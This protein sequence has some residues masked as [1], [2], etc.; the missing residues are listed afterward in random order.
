MTAKIIAFPTLGTIEISEEDRNLLLL[1]ADEMIARGGPDLLAQVL[2]GMESDLVLAAEG[3]KLKCFGA[4]SG[5]S[6]G[7]I[8]QKIERIIEEDLLRVEHYWDKPLIVHSPDG[9]N[10]IKDLWTEKTLSSLA[11]TTGDVGLIELLHEVERVH[12]DVKIKVLEIIMKNKLGVTL[13]V[14]EAWR[15]LEGKRMRRRIDETIAAIS[16]TKT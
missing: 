2:G 8:Q 9:W 12:R 13:Q 5:S 15:D 1:A 14:L 10:R 3:Q 16:Q 4:L 11:N 7:E 6:P